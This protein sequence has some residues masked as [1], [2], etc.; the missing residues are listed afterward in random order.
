MPLVTTAA[1]AVVLGAGN[2]QAEI[3]LGV[4]RIRQRLP[5]AGPTGAAVVLGGAGEQGQLTT[6]A[7]K[8]ALAHFLVQR[9]GERGLSALLAQ[10]AK[11]LRGESFAPLSITELPVRIRRRGCGGGFGPKERSD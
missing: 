3:H 10:D 4:D 1:A 7:D 8:G 6:G 2:D 5:E 11:R 9:T